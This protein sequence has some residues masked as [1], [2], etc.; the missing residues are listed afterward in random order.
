MLKAIATG[1]AL[2]C[3]AVAWFV[4][5]VAVTATRPNGA[6]TSEAVGLITAAMGTCGFGFLV[7]SPFVGL[8][9]WARK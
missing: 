7:A 1:A 8:F 9:N 3:A 6:L 2:I 4:F 5:G